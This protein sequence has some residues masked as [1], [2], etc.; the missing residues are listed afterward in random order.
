MSLCR[1]CEVIHC[2]QHSAVVDPA[3]L[4]TWMLTTV[5]KGLAL[6]CFGEISGCS[7][8]DPLLGKRPTTAE[9]ANI[10][11]IG[12][13]RSVTTD[14]RHDD[15]AVQLRLCLPRTRVSLREAESLV[16]F[17]PAI[18]SDVLQAAAGCWCAS[19]GR[20]RDWRS[21]GSVT[22]S[23]RPGAVPTIRTRVQGCLPCLTC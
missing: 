2:A 6:P 16:I 1:R 21:L 14:R 3:R 10:V 7:R 19:S 20:V 22:G 17:A 4:E 15:R 8:R 5:G 13:H 18:W 23:G 11:I 9:R 12:G